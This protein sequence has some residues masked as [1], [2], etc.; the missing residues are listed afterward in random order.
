VF[1]VIPEDFAVIWLG[2]W[3]YFSR[4]NRTKQCADAFAVGCVLSS[5][6]GRLSQTFAALRGGAVAARG[7]Q[8]RQGQTQAQRKQSRQAQANARRGLPANAPAAKGGKQQQQQQQGKKAAG[9]GKGG[10]GAPRGRGARAPTRSKP[11]PTTAEDLDKE[12]DTYWFKAG[13][14]P[15]PDA[16]ALD[17]EMEEYWAKKQAA[18]EAAAGEEAKSATA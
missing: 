14:G 15:D 6:S 1:Y 7:R 16:A 12:M 10:R 2:S 9:R 5:C 11:K 18:A 3:L 17:R 8:A 4:E 13:K